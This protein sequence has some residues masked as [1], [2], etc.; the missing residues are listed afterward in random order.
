MFTTPASSYHL[1][2]FVREIGET[3]K[4]TKQRQFDSPRAL[5]AAGDKLY[6]ADTDNHRVVVLEQNGKTAFTWGMKGS[7]QG[8]LKT[9]SGIAVDRQGRIYVADTDNDRIQ[10]FDASGKW[11]R[12]FGEKGVGPREFKSPGGIAV[13][14]GLVYIADT[15]NSRV[16]RRR[17]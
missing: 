13:A 17:S 1:I 9:P 15:G 5:V 8:Q 10:V 2:E 11:L 16:P 4:E 14:G 3:S 12:S 7:K 6:V